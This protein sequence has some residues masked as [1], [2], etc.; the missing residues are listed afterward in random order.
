MVFVLALATASFECYLPW[1]KD[2]AE[3]VLEIALA[4]KISSV[5]AV[6]SLP[7][8]GSQIVLLPPSLVSLLLFALLIANFGHNTSQCFQN[9]S[10][11]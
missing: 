1:P 2:Y 11:R 9:N 5:F 4:G 10:Q 3:R 7:V 8:E 6:L